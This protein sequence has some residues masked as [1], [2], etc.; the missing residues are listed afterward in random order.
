MKLKDYI[1]D[2]KLAVATEIYNA[3]FASVEDVAAL[4]EKIKGEENEFNNIIHEFNAI[5]YNIQISMSNLARKT[6]RLKKFNEFK[7]SYIAHLIKT[8][9]ENNTED[10]MEAIKKEIERS[11]DF[12]VQIMPK[13]SYFSPSREHIHIGYIWHGH[14]QRIHTQRERR[15]CAQ[16]HD[17]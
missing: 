11:N 16:H 10:N 6:K 4:M 1:A 14:R 8:F 17:Y 7:S 5:L 2:S 3:N 13:Q 12:G 15:G 9:I